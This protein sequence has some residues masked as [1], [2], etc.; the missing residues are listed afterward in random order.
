MT[1]KLLLIKEFKLTACPLT[2]LFTAFA[3]MTMIPNYPILVGSFFVCL[4]IFYTFQ[5]AREFNDVTYT[6][7]LPVA[8]RDVVRARFFFVVT[9]QA[10]SFAAIAA[11]TLLRMSL[12]SDKAPYAENPLMNAN[13]VYLGCVLV[14]FALFTLI[15]VR[16]FFRTA[17][18]FGKPFLLFS[19]AAFIVIGA[20]ETLHHLPGLGYLSTPGWENLPMQLTALC[21][22]IVIFAAGTWLAL[23]RSVRSFEKIDL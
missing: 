4:G 14:I 9:I 20:A 10:I 8:K 19:I 12:L 2:F 21:A 16:G 5:F 11:L 23:R 15:F 7:L 22:G 13:L 6:A 17:Y 1:M 3:L 18:Y